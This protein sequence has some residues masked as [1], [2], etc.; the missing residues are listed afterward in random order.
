MSTKGRGQISTHERLADDG[1][2]KTS[3]DRSFG[4]VFAVVFAIIGLWPV[5]F[6]GLPRWWSLAIAAAF[7]VVALVRPGLLAPL[8]RQ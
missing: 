3:S 5:P 7:L 4:I 8:N 2:I 1:D 6:G